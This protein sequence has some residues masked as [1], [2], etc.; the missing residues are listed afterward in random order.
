MPGV[1]QVM[2]RVTRFV[3]VSL[4][5]LKYLVRAA[6]NASALLGFWI[7]YKV[8]C[9]KRIL[10]VGCHARTFSNNALGLCI[11][12][13][14]KS[15]WLIFAVCESTQVRRLSSMGVQSLVIGSRKYAAYLRL[16]DYVACT[17]YIRGDI[18]GELNRGAIRLLLWHGM[19]L[20]GVGLQCVP[21]PDDVSGHD[22]CIATSDLTAGA[23]SQ[24]FALPRER[25]II[26]GE[27]KGDL[28][29]IDEVAAVTRTALRSEL[30]Q[31]YSRIIVYAPTWR[32]APNSML[33]GGHERCDERMIATINSLVRNVQFQDYLIKRNARFLIKLHPFHTTI[34]GHSSGPFHYLT[35]SQHPTERV[36][37]VADVVVTDYSSVLIDAIITTTLL[38]YVPDFK[39][40]KAI[41]PCPYYDLEQMFGEF[42]CKTP[43]DLMLALDRVWSQPE[44]SRSSVRRLAKK[45]H[46]YE[47]GSATVRLLAY[48]ESEKL[49]RI[50]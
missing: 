4:T 18:P 46:K 15:N 3:R 29:G 34:K 13:G 1:V 32:E 25:I 2:R 36:L 14:R 7:W 44:H 10:L 24:A 45:F 35:D 5:L 31:G 22:Y 21:E 47:T 28:V 50:P 17:G 8:L 33:D 49:S 26:C 11:G 23:M 12:G 37:G 40:Y 9:K 41:R 39:E 43:L 48:L 38:L 19:P 20:K 30:L 42:W 16:A 6:D 27:P